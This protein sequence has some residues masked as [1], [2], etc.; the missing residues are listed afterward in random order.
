MIIFLFAGLALEFCAFLW[1][2]AFS[3]NNRLRQQMS[4]RNAA[5]TGMWIFAVGILFQI[6]YHISL[7]QAG[8]IG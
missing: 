6:W 4:V 3:I 8:K 1:G 2:T 5:M 7:L